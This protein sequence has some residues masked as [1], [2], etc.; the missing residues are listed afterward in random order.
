MSRGTVCYNQS[1]MRSKVEQYARWDTPTTKRMMIIYGLLSISSTPTT[2]WMVTVYTSLS[3]S[4]TPAL[5][6]MTTGHVRDRMARIW[7]FPSA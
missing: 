5:M 3:I 6:W 2:K 7:A 1:I 4:A